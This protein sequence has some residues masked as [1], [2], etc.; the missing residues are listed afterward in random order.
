ML[1]LS[2][3]NFLKLLLLNFVLLL[4]DSRKLLWKSEEKVTKICRLQKCGGLLFPE[5]SRVCMCT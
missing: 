2:G 1:N 3:V 4:F 5:S